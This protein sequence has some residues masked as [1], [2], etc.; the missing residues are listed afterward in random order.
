MQTGTN[1]FVDLLARQL[2][3]GK[4]KRGPTPYEARDEVPPHRMHLFKE[5][6]DGQFVGVYAELADG[7]WRGSAHSCGADGELP[8]VE[9]TVV[10]KT[11]LAAAAEA[12]QALQ[13][14]VPQDLAEL[15]E[16]A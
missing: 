6:Y 11:P 14:G 7:G 10:H 4:F 12:L 3:L 15:L 1:P 16:T 13:Q 2:T 9:L 5:A 8:F